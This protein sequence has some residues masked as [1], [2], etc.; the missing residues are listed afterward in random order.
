M[1]IF[2]SYLKLTIKF[3]TQKLTIYYM[4]KILLIKNKALVAFEFKTPNNQL[5]FTSNYY[6]SKEQALAV[7]EAIK[8]NTHYKYER[9]TNVDGKFY[10]VINANNREIIGKSQVYSSEAGMENGINTMKKNIPSA[11]IKSIN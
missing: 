5:L 7:I 4:F 11:A 6:A 1:P 10:F 3:R 8:D 2:L 9:K